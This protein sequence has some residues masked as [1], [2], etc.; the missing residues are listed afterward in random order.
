MRQRI[1]NIDDCKRTLRATLREYLT[2]SGEDDDKMATIKRVLCRLPLEE[3]M[4]FI[5]HT[6]I[7]SYR[8]L[9]K[10]F[11]VSRTTIFNR[12]TAITKKIRESL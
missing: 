6:E 11:G 2:P 12:V 5:L 7:G 1:D 3:Q 8:Q 4:L 10:V 9:A